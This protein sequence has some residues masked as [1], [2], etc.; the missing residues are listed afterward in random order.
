MDRDSCC[1]KKML[2]FKRFLSMLSEDP[3]LAG[4]EDEGEARSLADYFAYSG[5]RP[6]DEPVDLSLLV[7][8][9][10]K[11]NGHVA[12]SE[13]MMEFVMNGGTIDAFMNV[14]CTE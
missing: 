9:L 10:L 14:A 4:R 3:S 13:Q 6:N 2:R 11:R 12:D 1:E 5:Y 8:L 7:S